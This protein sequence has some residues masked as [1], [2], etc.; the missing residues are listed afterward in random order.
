MVCTCA[1][2]SSGLASCTSN[3]APLLRVQWQHVTQ[4]PGYSAATPPPV[5]PNAPRRTAVS[6]AGRRRPPGT[7][8]WQEKALPYSAPAYCDLPKR[9]P[10]PAGA[11]WP[12][13]FPDCIR[14]PQG[15]PLPVT[16]SRP[17][18]QPPLLNPVSP[19]GTLSLLVFSSPAGRPRGAR[20]HWPGPELRCGAAWR[21]LGHRARGGGQGLLLCKAMTGRPSCQVGVKGQCRSWVIILGSCGQAHSVTV[22]A[23]Q[24]CSAGAG[25]R[26]EAPAGAG[27]QGGRGHGV[28][29]GE[30]RMHCLRGCASLLHFAV[31]GTCG[32]PWRWIP[33]PNRGADLLRGPQLLQSFQQALAWRWW[34]DQAGAAP[35][36]PWPRWILPVPLPACVS[37][38]TSKTRT[39]SP[40]KGPVAGVPWILEIAISPVAGLLV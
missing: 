33:L 29:Q 28:L 16:H 10:C 18:G 12:I 8:T 5:Q 22:A 4:P 32:L 30:P 15:A 17:S 13:A 1:R 7:L 35:L 19:G 27:R 24:P 14:S 40:R 6:R 11:F 31:A 34:W 21:H 26:R 25:G 38:R 39:T 23:S 37:C 2:S 3:A 36:K 9:Y 20:H